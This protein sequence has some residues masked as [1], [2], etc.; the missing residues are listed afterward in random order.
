MRMTFSRLSNM[1]KFKLK[2][3]SFTRQVYQGRKPLGAPLNILM[4]GGLSTGLVASQMKTKQVVFADEG[5]IP[6]RDLN[7]SLQRKMERIGDQKVTLYF[8]NV[9]LE[10][11]IPTFYKPYN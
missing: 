1:T 5:C 10:H 8:A 6:F 3:N 9:F 7:Y 4:F 2:P 11:F